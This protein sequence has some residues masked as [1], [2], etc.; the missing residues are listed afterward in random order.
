V[1]IAQLAA[2]VESVPPKG[3]GGTEVIV[4]LLTEALVE[5][6][7]DV[8]LFASGDSQTKG[9]LISVVDS[10]LRTNEKYL[11]RQWQSFD[12]Q[13]LLKLKSMQAEFDI[14][15]NHMGY[16]AL[17][18][19]SDLTVPTVTTL[20]NPIKP[21]N[22]PIFKEF[23]NLPY[24]AISN[25]YKQLNY[26]DLLN[27]VATI[28]NGIDLDLYPHP[29]ENARTYLLFLGRICHD[30]GTREAIA[31]ARTLGIAL[32]IAGKVDEPDRS[33]FE[34]V[35]KP[36]LNN[37]VE[38]VGEVDHAEKCRL[39]V[40]AIALIHAIN[41]DEPFGLTIV[42]SLACGTPV[43]ALARGSIPELLAHG[44]V[45][46]IAKTKDELLARFA[47]IKEIS[48]QDCRN[49]VEAGF[50]KECMVQ[51]YER[52]YRAQAEK[53]IALNKTANHVTA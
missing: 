16:Q 38:Y 1:R 2:N 17:P 28:Y 34:E 8:T 29:R 48:G 7:H 13:L 39:Y 26:G 11:P 43:M 33:Y 25:A 51:E 40:G 14:V 15:H 19:L 27:Y 52:L 44:K 22:F 24:V 35:I 6:G 30:K 12:I 42:E 41:F 10:S 5:R 36:Q 21:Y 46:I 31:M 18:V 45:A 20:H 53:F 47:E 9:R 4:N 49:H 32:K 50:S 3:Y 23:K 37:S